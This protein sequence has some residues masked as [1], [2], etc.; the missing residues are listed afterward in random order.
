PILHGRP[1]DISAMLAVAD[2]VVYVERC[3]LTSVKGIRKAKKAVKKCFQ[4]QLDGLGF[5]LVEL[6][7]PCPT[8]WKMTSQQ[9]WKWVDEV[10]TKTYPPGLIKD[11]TGYEDKK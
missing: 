7:S 1:I 4:V 10:M 5:A 9:A 6:L 3:S 8:N 11:T 2:G